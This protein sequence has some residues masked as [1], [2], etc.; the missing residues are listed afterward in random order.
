MADESGFLYGLKAGVK[1]AAVVGL[2]AAAAL[3][4]RR[5]LRRG[6]SAPDRESRPL[7]RARPL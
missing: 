7:G 6:D 5:T 1:G 4:V 2:A 3:L